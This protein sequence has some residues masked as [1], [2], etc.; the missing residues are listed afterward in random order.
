MVRKARPTEIYQIKV[1]LKGSKPP[2]WR[3]LLVPSDVTLGHLHHIIQV[4]MGWF[5]AH[6]HQFIVGGDTYYGVAD[7]DYDD[8]IEMLDER[9]FTL[10]DV[11][12]GEKSRFDYEYDFGDSWEHVVL[13]EKVLP[14]DPEQ[15][16]RVCIKGRRACPP[17]DVGGVWGYE[18]FLEAIEDP[19][20]SEHED[21]LEWIGGEFDPEE[22]DLDETNEILRGLG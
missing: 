22:F 12:P 15:A 6:L 3:R 20:H 10:K 1:T 7:P 8:W 14:P 13:V 16:Y 18:E 5:N 17:E 9:A 4:A 11:A 2:I 19:D 21:Y